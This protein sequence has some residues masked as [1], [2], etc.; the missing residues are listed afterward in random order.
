M[1]AR[2]ETIDRIAVSVGNR[3]ITTSDIER[4]IRVAAFISGSKPDL[5]PASRRAAADR[6]VDQKLIQA[7][8]ETARY[9]EPSPEEVDSALAAFKA[10]FYPAAEAYQRALAEAGVTEDDLKEF[11]HWQR[12]FASFVGVRFRPTANVS[13][14]DVARYFDRTVAP[15]ARAVSPAQTVTLDAYRARIV[16]KLTADLVDE[17]TEDWLRESRKRADIVFH[18]EAFQ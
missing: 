2:A 7:E 10:K 11:L 8:L 1:A 18:E 5:S 17:Q 15:A 9:P 6:I 14:Q 4:Q 3:V 12:R 16:E 13:E